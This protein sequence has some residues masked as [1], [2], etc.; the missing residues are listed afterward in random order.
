MRTSSSHYHHVS[1]HIFCSSLPTPSKAMANPSTCAQ[2]GVNKL[3]ACAV[4][5]SFMLQKP[6]WVACYNRRDCPQSLQYYSARQR[7]KLAQ[8]CT[9]WSPLLSS[10][11]DTGG[12]RAQKVLCR[13]NVV[14]PT[15][16]TQDIRDTGWWP[17]KDLNRNWARRKDEDER[18]QDFSTASWS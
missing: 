11:T 17:R 1:V 16:N 18:A 2:I 12:W 4:Y 8:A 14:R 6:S 13:R 5:G 7:K 10:N 3:H 15:Q 9:R